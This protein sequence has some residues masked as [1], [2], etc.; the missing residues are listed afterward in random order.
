MLIIG[1]KTKNLTAGYC[2]HQ[3]KSYYHCQYKYKTNKSYIEFECDY[4]NRNNLPIIVLYNSTRI[5]KNKCI[6]SVLDIAKAHTTM[7]ML[8]NDNRLYWDYQS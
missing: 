7:L 8:G 2:N 5:D 6:D 3:C 1:N 4:A